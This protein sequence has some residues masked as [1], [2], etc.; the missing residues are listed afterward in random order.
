MWGGRGVCFKKMFDV[1]TYLQTHTHVH[2]CLFVVV[3]AQNSR[4]SER[5]GI[6]SHTEHCGNT[7]MVQTFL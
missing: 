5:R 6:K 1:I 2:S 3:D 7:L 4:V